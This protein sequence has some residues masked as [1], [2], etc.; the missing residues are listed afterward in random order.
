MWSCKGVRR[1]EGAKRRSGGGEEQRRGGDREVERRVRRYMDV[2]CV[3]PGWAG[4]P[5]SR[6]AQ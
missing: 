6:Q 1:R 5:L 2:H 4:R 3:P